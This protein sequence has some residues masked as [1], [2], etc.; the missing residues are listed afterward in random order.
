[1]KKQGKWTVYANKN[2]ATLIDPKGRDCA[3]GLSKA[4]A[5]RICALLNRKEGK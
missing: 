4:L 1:M 3:V 2:G 5:R